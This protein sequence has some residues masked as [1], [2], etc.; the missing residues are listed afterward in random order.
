MLVHNEGLSTKLLS[1][2]ILISAEFFKEAHDMI[3][4]GFLWF[5]LPHPAFINP[6]PSIFLF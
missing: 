5:T 6:I 1:F 3:K 2:Q 4:E